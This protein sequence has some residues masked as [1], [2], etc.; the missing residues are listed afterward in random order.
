MSEL[1]DLTKLL[2][3]FP[4]S[5]VKTNPS[6]GGSYVTHSVV[7]QRLLDV[8]GGVDFTLVEVIRGT[9]QGVAPNPSGSSARA[10]R[11]TPDLTDAVVGVIC[12]MTAVIDGQTRVVEEVG[13]CE[14][15]HNWPHDGARMKD[16]FSDCYKRAAM[17]LGV[18]L[19]LWAQDG[20][21]LSEK[22]LKQD[23][24]KADA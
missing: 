9:V 15:P 5:V 22:L 20:F 17:R 24:E 10:K 2:H 7:E 14:Q 3:P 23:G 11:G 18:G 12:R 21:Y 8:L 13:D 19:H 6:G 1:R 4:S 16:A